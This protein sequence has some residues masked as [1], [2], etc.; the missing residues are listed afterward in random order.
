[1][2]GDRIAVSRLLV[3]AAA[4]LDR[5]GLYH[6]GIM[7]QAARL[8]LEVPE[9]SAGSCAGCGAPVTQAATGRPR[10]WC[11]E[12]CRDAARSR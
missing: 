2:T 6:A 5:R 1:M 8:L 11:S 12:R 9:Q 7:R 10:K 4:D 3:Q